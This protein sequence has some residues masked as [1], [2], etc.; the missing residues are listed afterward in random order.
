M[1]LTVADA[2]GDHT[3][4]SIALDEA[5]EEMDILHWRLTAEVANG[6]MTSGTAAQVTLLSP[7]YERLG[8]IMPSTWPAGS[9]PSI[10]GMG[11][12]WDHRGAGARPCPRGPAVRSGRRRASP[13]PHDTAC[14]TGGGET[15]NA[16]GH[17]L[18]AAALG[19]GPFRDAVVVG[20][21]GAGGGVALFRVW[22]PTLYAEAGAVQ[23][24]QEGHQP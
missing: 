9:A 11:L 17:P 1:W 10:R 19:T 4:Q 2:Y 18:G 24:I 5:D 7:F 22:Q 15:V 3:H 8:E 14:A 12:T 16:D 6:T 20:M 23:R 21:L 13:A